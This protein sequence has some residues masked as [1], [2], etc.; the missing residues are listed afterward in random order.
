MLTRAALILRDRQPFVDWSNAGDPSPT[1]HALTLAEVSQEGAVYHVEVEDEDELARWLASHQ[2]KLFEVEL[3][4]WYTY[5]VV[6]PGDRSLTMLKYWCS[7]ELHTVVLDT[8][9]YPLEDDE[10]T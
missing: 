8:A 1:S 6:C 10:E 4:G 9:A 5:P 7:F 3:N 2:Q